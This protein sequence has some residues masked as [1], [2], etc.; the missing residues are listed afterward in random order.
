MYVLFSFSH[1]TT[2]PSH[3]CSLT[4]FPTIQAEDQGFT[5]F[6]LYV[7]AAFLVKWSEKLQRMD[8]QEIMMFLQSL[9]TKEWTEKDVEL[10]LSEAFIWQSLFKGSAAHVQRRAGGVLEGLNL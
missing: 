7:C 6:H 1:F 4:S 8:F 5:A 9:P 2:N 3:D 10:L